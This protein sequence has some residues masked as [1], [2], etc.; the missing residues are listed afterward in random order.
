[1]LPHW[2]GGDERRSH[3]DAHQAPSST[4]LQARAVEKKE[5]NWSF[6]K[7]PKPKSCETPAS[8]DAISEQTL[9]SS[10]PGQVL[11]FKCSLST[12]FPFTHVFFSSPCSPLAKIARV[13]PSRARVC[14]E[15]LHPHPPHPIPVLP[16]A[17]PYQTCCP[18][19]FLPH[20]YNP[21]QLGK[22]DERQR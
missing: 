4:G 7:K 21:P 11:T 15:R 2:E 5:H 1:M 8:A 22:L 18:P 6:K 19:P 14:R 12:P 16:R 3:N 10:L 20:P 9:T 17:F 13:S